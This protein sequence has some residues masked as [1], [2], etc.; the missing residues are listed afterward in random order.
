MEEWWTKEYELITSQ[1]ILE[2]DLVKLVENSEVYI[3]SGVLEVF[4]MCKEK[5]IPITVLSAG[6]GNFIEIILDHVAHK[7]IT[8]VSN[9]LKFDHKSKFPGY[10][11]PI[12]HSGNKDLA[13]KNIESEAI[14]GIGDMPSVFFI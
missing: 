6:I 13:V 1:S 3:R 14:I 12:I 10:S 9:F 7:E 5:K 2:Q 11:L 8:L 4:E